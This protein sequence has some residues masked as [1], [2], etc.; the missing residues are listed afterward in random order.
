LRVDFQF[1]VALMQNNDVRGAVGSVRG[2][3]GRE[4]ASTVFYY[5]RRDYLLIREFKCNNSHVHT[6]PTP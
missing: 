1:V 6:A 2:E 4:A 3:I 5:T